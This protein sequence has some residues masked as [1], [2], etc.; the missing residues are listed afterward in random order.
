MPSQSAPVDEVPGQLGHRRGQFMHRRDVRTVTGYVRRAN[1]FKGHAGA[2]FVRDGQSFRRLA[3]G[4]PLLL[5]M[6]SR[7]EARDWLLEV[8]GRPPLQKPEMPMIQ[9]RD[10]EGRDWAVEFPRSTN[11]R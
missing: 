2:S 1:L 4:S 5:R 3:C 11:D 8:S 7:S 9:G 6:P 10:P